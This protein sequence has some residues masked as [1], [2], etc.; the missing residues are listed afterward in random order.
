MR[1]V[2]FK[3]VKQKTLKMGEGIREIEGVGYPSPLPF[4][5]KRVPFERAIGKHRMS[6]AENPTELIEK[7]ETPAQRRQNPQSVCH[8]G[9]GMNKEGH[10]GSKGC[11]GLRCRR[12]GRCGQAHV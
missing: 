12:C 8:L 1:V 2:G 6:K 5:G 11:Q 3:G 4:K 9:Q 10:V 7:D